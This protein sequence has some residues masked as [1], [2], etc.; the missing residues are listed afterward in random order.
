MGKPYAILS[1]IVTTILLCFSYLL[2]YYICNNA[3][4]I[5]TCFFSGVLFLFV[6]PYILLRIYIKCIKNNINT[7]YLKFVKLLLLPFFLISIYSLVFIVTPSYY[8][9]PVIYSLILSIEYLSC[10]YFIIFFM[11]KLV[12]L[13]NEAINKGGL[14]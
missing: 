8:S 9:H 6:V 3:D 14:K 7:V 5:L 12:A 2:D 10:I 11:K 4:N 1:N 13:I